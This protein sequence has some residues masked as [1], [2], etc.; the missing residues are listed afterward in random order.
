M[1]TPSSV[2]NIC[3]GVRLNPSYEHTIYFP[4]REAQ[5]EYFAGK[6]V[7]TFPAYTYL[8]KSW[9]IK[10]EA[11]M[12]QART[13]SYLF[14]RNGSGKTFYYF[15]TNIEYINDHTVL[16]KLEMD[17]MQTYHFDYTLLDSFVDR[18]HALYDE[19]GGNLVDEGLELGDY[20][21]NDLVNVDELKEM[22]ILL[23]TTID[24]LNT[25]KATDDAE[26]EITKFSG[27]NVGGVFSGVGV[28]ATAFEDWSSLC[29]K[30]YELDEMGVSDGIM[31]IWMYPKALV[32]LHPNF[33][34]DDEKV[35]KY[36]NNNKT[37]T[38]GDNITPNTFLD[39]YEPENKKLLSYPFNFLYVTNNEGGSAVYRY[40]RFM[41][42]SC[43]FKIGGSV[44]PE[45]S[46]KMYPLMYNGWEENYDEGVMGQ[47]YPTCAWNQ[48]TY[49]LWL[50][51]NQSQQ[52]LGLITGL[53][54]M[55]GG[56]VG[57]VAT[58]GIGGLAG[59][60]TFV[61][62]LSQIAS[63]LAQRRDAAIQ[64]PQARGTHSVNVNVTQKYHTFTFMKKSI[65]YE[66]ARII[67]DYFNMY[68]YKLNRVK[69]PYRNVRENW[70][71]TKTVGCHIMGNLCTDDLT[72]IEN[73]YNNGITFWV[74][75]DKI[76]D[77]SQS[78]KPLSAID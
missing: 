14:F 47:K 13:W 30:L 41:S 39:G 28:V 51:Q 21:V 66:H 15:I 34:W 2:I 37:I 48:D 55:V 32:G 71:Y 62:G 12:E 53:G 70:T 9:D 5:T 29:S 38:V 4:S 69:V 68:G 26:A 8:R 49:K 1:S 67:D 56:A 64:P 31:S 44:S 16:L 74:N 36:V 63:L 22:C 59:A 50:A 23:L 19:I 35:T 60:G 65:D 75:G 46:V 3:S 27:S 42:G 25:H 33:A 43:E 72:K 73:I 20:I 61:G 10:V 40:E 6:V 78:N 52:N 24:P 76:G 18:E 57:T 54:M 7:K 17:V 45:A 11:T 77:Y 58:G